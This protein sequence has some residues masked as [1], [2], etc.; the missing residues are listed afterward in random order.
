MEI[1]LLSL[2]ISKNRPSNYCFVGS[3]LSSIILQKT[4]QLVRQENGGG[5]LGAQKISL[6]SRSLLN[7]NI[8]YNGWAAQKKQVPIENKESAEE[9]EQD[10]DSSRILD[11]DLDKRGINTVKSRNSYLCQTCKKTL[12][13]KSSLN[14]HRRVHTGETPHKC[15]Y[16]KEMF[17]WYT[18]FKRHLLVHKKEIVCPVNGC[19]LKFKNKWDLET[20]CKNVHIANAKQPEERE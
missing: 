8:I 15:P 17:R 18:S 9:T 20:H 10:S 19:S 7:F 12:S 3:C 2:L 14:L 6:S 16:C 4:N 11:R 1:F 13:S 5:N